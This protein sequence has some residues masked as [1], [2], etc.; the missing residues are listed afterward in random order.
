MSGLTRD[1]TAELVERDG[2]LRPE[3][4]QGTENIDIT[5]SVQLT[6]SKIGDDSRSIP[7]QFAK[8]DDHNT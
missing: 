1:G 6:T 4:G 8:S 3:R 5:S 7:T 2:I